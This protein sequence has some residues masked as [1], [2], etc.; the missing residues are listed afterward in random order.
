MN[1]EEAMQLAQSGKKV[2]LPE[3]TGGY[4]FC[5]QDGSGKIFVHTRNG[6]TLDT[7]HLNDYKNREDW[8]ET[9]G[10]RDFSGAL[11][12]LKAGKVLSR[13]AWENGVP[14][15]KLQVPDA[16]SKMTKPYI[17]MIK[18]GDNGEERFPCDLSCESIMAEDWFIVEAF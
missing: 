5:P 15:I 12:A 11:I 9:D 10:L 6:E 7:P 8:A 13:K 16:N 1:F 4:W 3:W 14:S 18:Q 2:K 17:Y